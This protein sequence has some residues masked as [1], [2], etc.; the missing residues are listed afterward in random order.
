MVATFT[1]KQ[2]FEAIDAYRTWGDLTKSQYKARLLKLLRAINIRLNNVDETR[3]MSTDMI[4]LLKD[5]K[6]LDRAKERI[7]AGSKAPGVFKDYVSPLVGLLQ[8]AGT[9]TLGKLIPEKV[10]ERADQLMRDQMGIRS[11]A[12]ASRTLTDEGYEP[13]E[14][15]QKAA[16]WIHAK[17]LRDQSALIVS[18]YGDNPILVRDNYGEVKMFYGDAVHREKNVPLVDRDQDSY[19]DVSTGRVYITQF[20]T[21]V[22]GYR[23]YDVKLHA[24]TKSMIDYQLKSAR[25]KGDDGW[26]YRHYLFYMPTDPT[27]PFGKLGKNYEIDKAMRRTGVSFAIKVPNTIGP[28]VLRSSYITYRVNKMGVTDDEL[29]LLARDMKHSFQVQQLVYKRQGGARSQNPASSKKRKQK[30]ID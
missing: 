8:K 22:K 15:I 13:Y 25:Q 11:V 2:A 6:V 17:K 26:G 10:Q 1:I 23:P 21:R 9:D 7:L 12:D 28:N 27:K 4:N 18:I 29:V 20:K 30:D 24:R 14:N 3:L 16:D 5:P 19:Y